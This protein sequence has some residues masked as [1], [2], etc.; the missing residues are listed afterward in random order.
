[1]GAS[2]SAI[3]VPA[4]RKPRKRDHRQP[5]WARA[6]RRAPS[7]SRR[8]GRS[9]AHQRHGTCQIHRPGHSSSSLR[10]G[11]HARSLV[12]I[13]ARRPQ[14]S[15]GGRTTNSV[16]PTPLPSVGTLGTD[17]LSKRQD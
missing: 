1:V 7:C 11:M 6:L 16:V 14:V 3:A 17:G 10:M 15:A 13:P 4:R 12:E 8:R 2:N 9:D 5:T